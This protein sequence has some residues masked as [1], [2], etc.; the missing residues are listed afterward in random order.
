MKTTEELRKLDKQK[1]ADE[2]NQTGKD[3]FKVKF[4]VRGGQAKN[5][6]DIKKNRRQIARIKTIQKEQSLTKVQS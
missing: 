4:E 5:N 2:L 6:R 3:Y 1:L